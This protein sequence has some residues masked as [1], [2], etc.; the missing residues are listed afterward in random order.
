MRSEPGV[1]RPAIYWTDHA[2]HESSS[3]MEEIMPLR[4]CES[5][6]KRY[7]L[8]LLCDMRR[9]RPGGRDPV[10]MLYA[11]GDIGWGSGPT[12]PGMRLQVQCTPHRTVPSHRRASRPSRPRSPSRHRCPSRAAASAPGPRRRSRRTRSPGH[13]RPPASHPKL[14]RVQLRPSKELAPPQAPPA[15]GSARCRRDGSA[16]RRALWASAPSR[17]HSPATPSPG[18]R[19]AVPP[20]NA[21][22]AP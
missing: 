15:E 1:M 17:S 12:M 16:N 13:G 22:A 7:C 3:P 9:I 10:H 11:P 2:W 21:A 6:K 4:V 5:I 19:R 18:R 20:L 8:N 14:R